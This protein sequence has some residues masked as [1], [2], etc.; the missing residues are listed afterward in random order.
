ME[1]NETQ[2]M[3][4]FNSGYLL[5]QHEPL[6]LLTLLKNIKSTTSYIY[7]MSSG[8]QEFE[9]ELTN[10][11][12]NALEQLRREDFDKDATLDFN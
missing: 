5:A 7:G 8:K 2:F 12:L 10:K 4:G 1:L 6:L 11:R 9:I 3:A